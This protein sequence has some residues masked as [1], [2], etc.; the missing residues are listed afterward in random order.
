MLISVDHKGLEWVIA[1]Y[2]SQDPTAM[3]EIWDG[4]D[5][6]ADNQSRF[7]LPERVIAK[8]FLFRLIYCKEETA[9][10][11]FANDANFNHVSKD[12]KFWQDVIDGFYTKYPRLFIGWHKELMDEVGKTGKYTAID[13]R[14]Y[15]FKPYKSRKG[16]WELPKTQ[17]Y[18]YPVQGLG[19][20]LVMLSRIS[21]WRRVNMS[22]QSVPV[23]TKF[24]NTVHD[25]IWLDTLMSELRG[26]DKDGNSCYNISIEIKN[27]FEALPK[28]F[29]KV[30]GKPFNLPCRYEIKKLTGE[31]IKY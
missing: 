27:V 31:E 14:V 18:N 29:E 20:F 21:L 3:Q 28:N 15:Q 26:I 6:H 8:T 7:N 22:A 1:A 12:V 5:L 2:L 11:S 30:T 9:A 4:V 24:V 10:W 19:A 17:I 25:D 16:V 23:Y 13:G